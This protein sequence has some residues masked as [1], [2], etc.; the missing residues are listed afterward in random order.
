MNEPKNAVNN[1][2]TDGTEENHRVGKKDLFTHRLS[3]INE[4]LML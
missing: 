2:D 4:N 3:S 1:I